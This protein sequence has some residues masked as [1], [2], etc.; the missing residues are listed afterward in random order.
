MSPWPGRP[1]AGKRLERLQNRPPPASRA[2]APFVRAH[3]GAENGPFS[4][5]F[6]PPFTLFRSGA[7]APFSLPGRKRARPQQRSKGQMSKISN[8]NLPPRSALLRHVC[9]ARRPPEKPAGV[10]NA[11]TC[12]PRYF[13]AHSAPSPRSMSSPWGRS[14]KKASRLS[15]TALGL[16]GRLT[17]RVLP[18]MAA[19]PREN[20]ARRV[21]CME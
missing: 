6:P 2:F 7:C 13:L 10:P 1:P 17:I 8:K 15:C 19:T 12:G 11:L 20:I 21:I 9:F 4:A 3:L 5:R 16:P 14:L 18:R